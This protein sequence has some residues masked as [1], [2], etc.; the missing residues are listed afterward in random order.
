MTHLSNSF[1]NDL[2]RTLG[3]AP[4]TYLYTR[5]TTACKTASR[6]FRTQTPTCAG[7]IEIAAAENLYRIARVCSVRYVPRHTAGITG[8]GH[9]GKFG[10]ASIPVPDT[11]VSSVRHQYRYRTLANIRYINTGT[12]PFGKFGTTRIPVPPVP[13]WTSVPDTSESSAKHDPV[14]ETWVR[15]VRHQPVTTTL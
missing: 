8:T 13:V 2:I 9:F 5:Y 14:P 15:S 10:T 3:N 6:S 4:R 11:S 1:G 12:G 7:Y